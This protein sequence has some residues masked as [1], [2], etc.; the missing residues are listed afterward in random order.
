M[1]A[2][3]NDPREEPVLLLTP[4]NERSAVSAGSSRLAV[5]SSGKIVL[6]D[7]RKEI[8]ERERLLNE[9][10]FHAQEFQE[11]EADDP[12]EVPRRDKGYLILSVGLVYLFCLPFGV[13][14]SLDVALILAALL[15]F[16]VFLV[17][18]LIEEFTSF[19]FPKMPI[20]LIDDAINWL[21]DLI[22]GN[23]T[24][25]AI[26]VAIFILLVFWYFSG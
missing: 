13:V 20:P 15:S 24:A 4:E 25:A 19:K 10:I 9:K 5:D 23:A 2:E 11:L 7:A 17:V 8:A 21:I 3:K 6:P 1:T 18:F 26:A 14:P 22:L 16:F 12:V